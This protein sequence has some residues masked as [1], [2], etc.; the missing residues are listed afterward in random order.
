MKKFIEMALS[1]LRFIV[2]PL[3]L[4]YIQ[5]RYSVN[6]HCTILASKSFF[7]TDKINICILVLQVLMNMKITSIIIFILIILQNGVLI[8]FTHKFK[9]ITRIPIRSQ[10]IIEKVNLAEAELQDWKK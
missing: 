5:K 9:S 3:H 7:S 2:P 4:H 10:R 6:C 1:P 8:I